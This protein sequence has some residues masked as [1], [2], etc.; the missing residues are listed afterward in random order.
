MMDYDRIYER[1]VRRGDEILKQRQKRAVRIKQTSYAVSGVCAAVIAGVGIWRMSD[2]KRLPEQSFSEVETVPE[3]TSAKTATT[4][5]TSV[6]TTKTTSKKTTTATASSTVT[7]A[8]TTSMTDTVA[9]IKPTE[10]VRTETSIALT[11]AETH[12]ETSETTTVLQQTEPQTTLTTT[13]VE[14]TGT[15]ETMPQMITSANSNVQTIVPCN[16]ADIQ[17][18][19]D[20]NKPL[21]SFTLEAPDP[22]AGNY[23]LLKEIQPYSTG[24]L[25]KTAHLKE[26]RLDGGKLIETES[27]ADIYEVIGCSEK[28]MTAVKYDGSEKFFCYVNTDYQP[29]TLGELIT[30]F[31]LSADSLSGSIMGSSTSMNHADT[32]KIWQLLTADTS[33]PNVKEYCEGNGITLKNGLRIVVSSPEVNGSFLIS[34]KGY[35]QA[36]INRIESYYYMGAERAVEIMTEIKQS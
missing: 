3:T 6:S 22:L 34:A 31:N 36:N 7:S 27:D 23:R 16:A 17:E 19:I 35:I 32:E 29:Q 10:T 14:E 5:L 13:N 28:A 15:A 11:L 30:A 25:L 4:A 24:K 20:E 33:L 12:S 8:E 26:S 1:V 21:G 2:L 18:A 9:E